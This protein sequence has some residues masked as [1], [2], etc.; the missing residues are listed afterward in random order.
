MSWLT[1]LWQKQKHALKNVL[2]VVAS[3]STMG[4]TVGA[5]LGETTLTGIFV[6]FDAFATTIPMIRDGIELRDKEKELQSQQKISA[7]EVQSKNK[8]YF[9][10]IF[11]NCVLAVC[12]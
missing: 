12:L 7:L 9:Y 2:D 11:I 8:N 4:V 3:L 10:G 6:I 1:N 5:A